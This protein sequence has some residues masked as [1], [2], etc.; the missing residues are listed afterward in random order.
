MNSIKK[1]V[2]KIIPKKILDKRRENSLI[3]KVLLSNESFILSS[4][5]W[6]SI[7]NNMPI[8]ELGKPLPWICYPMIS[9]LKERLRKDM[10]LFEYGSG[11]STL[12]FADYVSKIYSVEYDEVWYEKMIQLSRE[13]SNIHVIYNA[14]D[15]DYAEVILK[16]GEKNFDVI[17]VDGRK[18]VQCCMFSI[19][20]LK[21]DGII[22]LDDSEREKYNDAFIFLKQQGYSFIS[23]RG[24]KPS[25]CKETQSTIFYKRGNN[26]FNI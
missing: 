9:F 1:I 16:T 12:F 17:F 10:V 26:C 25:D 23:L 19:N 21:D 14:I 18:R 20:F 4:G 15:N 8:D 6:N 13:V 22:I 3:N 11:F 7:K 2:K 5:L 24:M